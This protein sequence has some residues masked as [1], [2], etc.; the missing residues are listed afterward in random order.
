MKNDKS[1]KSTKDNVID[2]TDRITEPNYKDYLKG[3][4][5][6]FDME[7]TK[8]AIST[9]LLSIVVLVTLANN[10]LVTS[11]TPVEQNEP[12]RATRGIASVPGG[13]LSMASTQAP[14]VGIENPALLKELASRDLSPEAAV[15]R[16]PT[17]LE[18]LAFEVLEGK[19]AV[20]VQDGVI[21]EIELSDGFG[22]EAKQLDSLPSFIESQRALLP[23]YDRVVKVGSERE[24]V[25][26]IETFQ[27]VNAVSIPVAKV[28]VRLDDGGRFVGMRVAQLRLA[29]GK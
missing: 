3:L 24:G 22:A 21:N 1:G 25:S 6:R 13:S 14:S 12:A 17:A 27:L 26:Q 5:V 4:K 8:V 11:I 19:Y 2:M 16:K 7:H 23:S 29:S 9:S 18:K 28:Q 15:G 10:N 20:R